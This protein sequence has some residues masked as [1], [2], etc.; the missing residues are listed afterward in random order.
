MLHWS[1]VRLARAI[2][3]K[4]VSPVE[5]TRQ[6]LE[7]I[8]SVDGKLNAFI[9]VLSEE[10][11][12]A[13]S[14]SEKE[15]LANEP[16][17]PLHGVPVGLKDIIYTRGIKTTMGSEIFNDYVPDYDATVVE[18][19]KGAG[20]IIVG[21][22]NTHQFAY[23]PTG[24]RSYFGPAR[25]PYDSTKITGGSSAG[26]GA[27][28]AAA[29]CYAALGTDTGGSVRIPASCC[30]IVGMKPTFGRVSKYGVFPLSW[31]L[32]HVGPMTR[33]VEDNALLLGV[34]A[35]HDARDP[36][37]ARED[38]EDFTRKLDQGIEGSIVGIPS[39]FYFENVEEEVNAKVRQ[40][41]ETLHDLGA[42]VREVKIPH[43]REAV[44]AQRLTLASEAFTVHRERLRTQ[45][46][47]FEAEVR[48][49][50]LTGETTR[51]YEYV[52]AQQ[53]KHLAVR[54]F[55]QALEEVDVLVSPTTPLLPTDIDQRKVDFNGYKE[56]IRSAITRL[57]GPTNLNGFPALSVPCGFSRS[58]LP[59]G[60]QLTGKPL[61]EANLYRFGLA[62]EQ[63]SSVATS[64]YRLP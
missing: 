3:E 32:D 17:G 54:E 41:I 30:G 52:E 34:L 58:G 27:A 53:I 56:H 51:A 50:L 22:L 46:E 25:N 40:A 36:Y 11:L 49:R 14:R 18:K 45:S 13:A 29:L 37:S 55:N 64:K 43:I 62:V 26:S 19:L 42:E 15:I 33:T 2:K 47:R 5:V 4:E 31:T 6:L 61:D 9:T 63:A 12:A 48:E 59:I 28:V 10:S 60:L 1:L 44:S 38:T 39:P 16:K 20:A 7:R 23:G 24:D 57:A 35:G 8:D 21:K